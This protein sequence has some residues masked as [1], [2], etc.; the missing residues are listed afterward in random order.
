MPMTTCGTKLAA[1][2]KSTAAMAVRLADPG[3]T[4]RVMITSR[5]RDQPYTRVVGVRSSFLR[6]RR[7]L[8]SALAESLASVWACIRAS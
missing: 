5:T 8:R 2:H 4:P 7:R 1:R 6:S 3:A